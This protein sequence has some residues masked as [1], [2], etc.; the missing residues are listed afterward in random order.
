[1]H[2]GKRFT[3][4]EFFRWTRCDTYW[5]LAIM[6]PASE[7]SRVSTDI[8]AGAVKAFTIGRSECVASMGAS[9]VIV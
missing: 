7:M 6:R 8:P 2:T 1:M 3:P 9:S 5:M 4:W